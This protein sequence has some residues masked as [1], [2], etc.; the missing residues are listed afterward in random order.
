[1]KSGGKKQL[2]SWLLKDG[3]AFRVWAPFAKNVE[4]LI[5]DNGEHK[6]LPMADDGGYWSTNT[7]V[8]QPGQN[9]HYLITTQNDEVL[10][11]NDPYAR[12][13]TSSNNGWS[14]VVQDNFDWTDDNF[15]AGPLREQVIY[16]LHI[17]T[18]NKPDAST[19]GTFDSAVE[20]L[21][22][23]KDLGVSAIEILPV[24]SMMDDAGWGYAP[25]HLFS[26]EE[27]YGGRRG[28]MEFVNAAHQ[29]G[30]AVIVDLV[31]NHLAPR[32]ELTRFDGWYENDCG[33][34]YF[35]N[36]ERGHTPWGER[37]D[38]GRPEVREYL[39][40]NITMWFTEF[41]VD[42]M[43]LDATYYI[44]KLRTDDGHEL[45]DIPDGYS[46]LRE[47]TDRAHAVNPRAYMIA[48]DSGYNDNATAKDGLAFDA[49]WATHFPL[50][51]RSAMGV[52][53]NQDLNVFIDDLQHYFNNDAFQ[54]VIYSDSH[55]SAANGHERINEEAA[56]GGK[57]KLA[58]QKSL[59]A[60]TATFTAPGIPMLLQG[61]EFLE[62]GHFT[63]WKPLNWENK[64]KFAG[65]MRAHQDLMKLRRTLPALS[66]Y[67]FMLFHV[68]YTDAVLGYARWSDNGKDD[69]LVLL[70]FG[71]KSF[72]EYQ[73]V[74]HKTGQ[75]KVVFDSCAKVYGQDLPGSNSHTLNI[76]DTG[77]TTLSLQAYQA[78]VFKLDS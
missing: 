3:V 60:S 38:Y 4:L 14:V 15:Q 34:I 16:E 18:F 30:L 44:D 12:R 50:A 43:R 53:S 62:N 32:N 52:E 70:N 78:L 45:S 54:K 37:P 22:H 7:D 33:G 66:G 67:G 27:V 69:A 51:I 47:M 48:E 73:I 75:W 58:R 63:G 49:Q 35:Y 59:L 11:R 5:D 72:N 21:G 6:T 10:E 23:L 24:T 29:H 17:G 42:G 68:N 8:I 76:D 57:T 13:L 19:P 36:D 25:T 55:D 20:N 9:Y 40:D 41:H 74:P 77:K 56:D 28:L 46:L 26:I 2:G 64:E 61:G 31:Y 39:L 71:N 65:I 1:M